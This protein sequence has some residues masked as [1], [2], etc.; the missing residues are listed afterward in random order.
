MTPLAGLLLRGATLTEHDD[1]EPGTGC[2]GRPVWN[3]TGMLADLE[4][5]LG[6]PPAVADHGVRLQR[7][8]QRLEAAARVTP[9][10]YSRSYAI[11]PIGTATT[12]LTWRDQL[13]DSGWNGQAIP[14]GG[15]RLETFCELERELELPAGPADRLRRVQAELSAAAIAPWG[16]LELAESLS[17]WPERWRRVFALLEARGV[18]VKVA[19][20]K[21]DGNAAPDSDLGRLQASIRGQAIAP[22]FR[23]DG[24][25]VLLTG[26][27]SWE[28]AHAVAALLERTRGSSSVV[29]RGGDPAPLDTAFAAQGLAR[30]GLDSESRWRPALQLLPLA[31]ELSYLPRDPYRMLELVT[32]PLGPFAG[33]VGLQLARAISSSPGVGGRD[34]NEAKRR[35]GEASHRPAE[36]EARTDRLTMIAEWLEGP[37]F[38]QEPGAPRSHLLQVADRVASYLKTRLVR[39]RLERERGESAAPHDELILGAAFGQAQAFH[40]ALSHDGRE[41]LD[42]VAVRQ[43]LEEVSLGS[44]SLPLG[45]EEAGRIDLVDGPA[46]LRCRR[47][48]VVWWHCVNGAQAGTAIDPW[49]LGEKAA[50]EAAGVRLPDRGALLAAEVEAWR[51]VVLAADRR[52]ILVAPAAAQAARLEAHPIRDE[53]VARASAEAADV[54]RV[55]VCSEDLLA[56]DREIARQLPVAVEALAPLALPPA[57][58]SWNAPVSLVASPAAYSASSLEEVLACPLAWVFNRRAGLRGTWALGIASGPLLNGRLGHRLIEE[59]HAAGLFR[60]GDPDAVTAVFDRLIDEDGAVLRRPGM[61]FELSQL[62]RQLVDG[63]QRLARILDDSALSIAEVEATTSVEWGE[64][65]LEGRLDLVLNDAAGNEVVLDVKWGKSAYEQKLRDGLAIQ[66]ATYSAAR[67]IEGARATMPPVAYFALSS[68]ALLTTERDLFAGC[69]PLQG[70]AISETWKKVERTLATA[71]RMLSQGDIPVTGLAQSPSLLKS[72]GIPESEHGEHVAPGPACNYCRYAT[73]CGKAWEGL[74]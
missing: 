28:L 20:P 14:G 35:I 47:D 58:V 36:G 19:A 32:L 30:Q 24:S 53:L 12:L 57:R 38:D 39:A 18:A 55:S 44:V 68:G 73:L 25:F 49:R 54:A 66:L 59:L 21:L 40:E 65:K 17:A 41:H 63:V 74:S 2:L 71:E 52:L 67:K 27:T 62:R 61:T 70:P 15:E 7:W 60:D 42:L 33:W 64:R 13:I 6:L 29:V 22:G 23:G 5:R 56:G 9:C 11:D 10:F 46:G 69:R 8:S 45:S 51:R 48:T 3:R 16:G 31:L 43:L 4:L 50:L 34:W 72:A 1:L 26:E 37:G